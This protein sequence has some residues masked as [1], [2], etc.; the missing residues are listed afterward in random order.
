MMTWQIGVILVVLFLVALGLLG[1][2]RLPARV[3]RRLFLNSALGLG[4]ILVFNSLA[5][6]GVPTLAINGISVAATS[7]LG[8]PGAFLLAAVSVFLP[9]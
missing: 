6:P 4:L 8:I 3:I 1:S 7:V 2:R 5:L 9:M